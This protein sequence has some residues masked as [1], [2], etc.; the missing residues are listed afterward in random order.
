MICLYFP[1]QYQKQ[2]TIRRMLR[3]NSYLKGT[4]GAAW[5]LC[6]VMTDQPLAS[7]TGYSQ[8][9][10][11][12][13]LKSQPIRHSLCRTRVCVSSEKR[14]GSQC[15]RLPS[16]SSSVV[17]GG[18]AAHGKLGCNLIILYIRASHCNQS[19]GFPRAAIIFPISVLSPLMR[20]FDKFPEPCVIWDET[21]P[22]CEATCNH[23]WVSRSLHGA[24][25]LVNTQ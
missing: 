4:S 6:A 22:G 15:L 24:G 7:T 14:R 2:Q 9:K 8:G 13:K 12:F 3:R 21:K 5:I 1:Y 25:C 17:F 16:L 20:Q 23:I 18:W 11:I 19:I 10:I